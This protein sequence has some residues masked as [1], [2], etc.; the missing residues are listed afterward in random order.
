MWEWLA[1]N[2]LRN[3]IA[4]LLSVAVITAF[5]GYEA[6]LVQ[7]SYKHGGLLPE[8]DSAYVEYQRFLQRKAGHMEQAGGKLELWK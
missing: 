6:T 7:M 3:R 1:N 2:V 5:M 8:T 4:I